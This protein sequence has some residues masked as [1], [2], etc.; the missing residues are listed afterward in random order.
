MANIGLANDDVLRQLLHDYFAW[1]A[2]TTMSSYHLSA[3]DGPNG[4]ASHNCSC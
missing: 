4:H 2:T 1:A 3:D